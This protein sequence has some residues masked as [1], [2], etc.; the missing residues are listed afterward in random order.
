MMRRIELIPESYL[1]KRQRRRTL[2]MIAGAGLMVVLLLLLYW[3]YL[4]MQVSEANQQLADVQARNS[5]LQAEITEL[6]RFAELETEVQ[7]KQAALTTV[8]A[9][10]LDWPALLTEVAM[11]APGEVWLETLTASAGTTEGATQ[12]GTETAPIRV[13]DQTP[14]GRIQFTGKSTSMP[15]VAKWLVRLRT[16][17]EFE[18]AW[19][20]NA[21]QSEAETGPAVID[22]D[23]TIELNE[24]A[25]SGRFQGG[26][27]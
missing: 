16:S 9:G 17:K 2:G 18:A 10:D 8:M 7:N 6:Q 24:R 19:L 1:R 5:Q 15:G 26:Q 25:A 21:N 22:F 14:A 20:N 4:T 23:T 13:S 27:Q 3:V 12:V 11:I